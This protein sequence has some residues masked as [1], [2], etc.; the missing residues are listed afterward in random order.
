MMR[1]L[2][3]LVLVAAA[4][5]SSAPAAAPAAAKVS[6]SLPAMRWLPPADD[7]VYAYR[8]EN[9]VEGGAGVLNLRFRK[10]GDDTVELTSPGRT[11]TLRYT[12]SGIVRERTGNLLLRL[13]IEPGSSWPAGPGSSAHFGRTDVAVTCEAGSFKGCVEVVEERK[14]P[15]PGSI[16]TTFCPDVGIVRIETRADE[17]PVHEKVELRSFGKPIDINAVK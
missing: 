3:L 4:G 1:S 15:V 8:T 7:A 13:P 2:A 6:Y 5:C 11:E 10:L 9:M 12:A 14:T 16:T 17:P